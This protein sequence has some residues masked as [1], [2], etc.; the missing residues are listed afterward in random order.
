MGI[1]RT[2]AART[3]ETT[4]LFVVDRNVCHYFLSKYPQVADQI[5]EKLVERK[6]E[7]VERQQLLREMGVLGEEE[8]LEINPLVWIRERMKSLFGI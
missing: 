7:L 8:D 3:I 1:P 4:I 2:A 6:Q 5:A